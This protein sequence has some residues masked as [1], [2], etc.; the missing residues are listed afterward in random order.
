M[1]SKHFSHAGRRINDST[2]VLSPAG[3][4]ISVDLF[5]EWPHEQ[6]ITWKTSSPPSNRSALWC[7]VLGSCCWAVPCWGEGWLDRVSRVHGCVCTG[8]P[9]IRLLV[10]QG[11]VSS[12]STIVAETSLFLKE[13]RR[14]VWSSPSTGNT[15]ALCQICLR[16]DR[17]HRPQ[18]VF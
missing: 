16:L 7:L 10:A 9:S 12:I 2:G 11:Q 6:I 3:K 17:E 13:C 18:E 1:E 15:R 5:S 8:Q 14:R 4:T